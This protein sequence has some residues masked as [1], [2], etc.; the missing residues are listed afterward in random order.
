MNFLNKNF[1]SEEIPKWQEKGLIDASTAQKIASMYD[2]DLQKDS[3]KKSFILQL[4]AYLFLALA[5]ITF[6]G[7]NWDE[8][9]RFVR[10]ILVAAVVV[11]VNGAG[12][13]FVQKQK[14]DQATGLFFLGNFCY[15]GAIA[16]IAQIYHL[17][18]H[19]PNGILLWAIGSMV[20]A[21]VVQKSILVAQSLVIA[22][23]WFLVEVIEYKMVSHGF[24][25]FLII[26]AQMLYREHSKFLSLSLFVSCF[27][28]LIYGMREYISYFYIDF[29]INEF[30][31]VELS[32]CLLSIIT[33]F[34]WEKFH[35]VE[36]AEYLRNMS[37]G[38][39]VFC[40]MILLFDFNR[41]DNS[42][43]SKDYFAFYKN[44]YGLL[45]LIFSAIS[46]ALASRLKNYYLI[47]TSVVLLVLPLIFNF[48]STKIV[49]SI[50]N[51][52]IGAFLIKQDRLTAGL[53]L[54]FFVALVRY[55]DLIGDYIGASIL[56]LIFAIIILI[57][58]RKRRKK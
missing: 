46:L 2:V 48:V 9:P 26:S 43:E 50:L 13:Y 10:L 29:L 21:V 19:M 17:G 51:V 52:L 22:L 45:Y 8:I 12:F 31:L 15:G 4:I 32:Y 11:A 20:L 27:V 16:L 44:Y 6:I 47:G 24:L 57:I 18:E 36:T 37:I 7:A 1:L 58:N 5:F 35:R 25:V 54:I 33:S 55:I 42:I 14:Q 56:F 28:Y 3:D 49:F 39:G 38:F 30:L 41:Y 23:I 53:S 40:L 34:F